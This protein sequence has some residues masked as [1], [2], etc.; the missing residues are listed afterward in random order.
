MQLLGD[1]VGVYRQVSVDASGASGGGTILVGGDYQ[2]NHPLLRNAHSTYLGPAAQLR[3]D[4][5]ALGA[6]QFHLP[7]D[8]DRCRK[9]VPQ[10]PRYG[11]VTAAGHQRGG[12]YLCEVR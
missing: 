12:E 9:G 5:T 1:R 10:T 2:G 6:R 11:A 8:A 4:A 7:A 3:A